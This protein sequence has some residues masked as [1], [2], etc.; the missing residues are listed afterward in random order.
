M[1]IL[2]IL[3]IITI[4]IVFIVFLLASVVYFFGFGNRCDKNPLIKYFTPEEFSIHSEPVTIK[5]DGDVLC[6]LKY[7]PDQ[8]S[9]IAK[10]LIIFCHG[11]GPGHCAYTTEIAYFCQKGFLVL[12]IDN[13]GCN[14]SSGKRMKGMYEGVKSCIAAI[15]YARSFYQGKIYIVGHSWG[16]YS[17]LCA[18]A[19]RKVDGVIALSSPTN[20][21]SV[22]TTISSFFLPK[23]IAYFMKPFFYIIGFFLYGSKGNLD[24]S[25]CASMSNTPILLIHGDKDS[26]VPIS[27]SAF[28]RSEGPKIRKFLAKGKCHNPYN[29]EKAE[30]CLHQLQAKLQLPPKKQIECKEYFQNFNYKAATEEDLNVMNIILDFIEQNSHGN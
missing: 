20:P 5:S 9:D 26:M 7:T 12:A 3:L 2:S 13:L 21:S 11:M 18:S 17:A 1:S 19:I 28:Q 30:Q 22:L 27:M 8:G 4:S 14:L 29:T 10:G 15:D 25:K 24:A 23:I 16:A 6:G